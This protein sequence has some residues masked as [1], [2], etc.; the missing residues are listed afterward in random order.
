[1]FAPQLRGWGAAFP[2][3][4]PPLPPPSSAALDK[5]AVK[6]QKKNPEMYAPDQGL[7]TLL[8]KVSN[9]C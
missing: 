9:F 8:V 5:G 2:A 1:M 7:S 4:T 6:E 3:A